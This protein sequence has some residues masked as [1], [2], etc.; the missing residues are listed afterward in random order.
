MTKTM[1]SSAIAA[2]LVAVSSVGGAGVA[3]AAE[4]PNG[5]FCAALVDRQGETC[6]STSEAEARA[7][8]GPMARTRLMTYYSD[9]G[10]KGT[11][12]DVYGDDGTCNASGYTFIPSTWWQNRLS[13]IRGYGG[14]TW[15]GL[16]TIDGYF[17]K[18]Y[19]LPASLGATSYNDNTGRV[20]VFHG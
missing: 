5:R 4:T 11:T 7:E 1:W 15:V 3:A 16:T 17:V 18:A 2:G 8:L 14:C 13:S 6:S 10:W 19:A 9:A 20:H 12:L